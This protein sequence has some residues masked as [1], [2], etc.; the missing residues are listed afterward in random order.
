MLLSARIA[1][2]NGFD[3]IIVVNLTTLSETTNNNSTIPNANNDNSTVH[4]LNRR[5][6]TV[7]LPATAYGRLDTSPAP[8]TVAGIIL[9]TVAGFL[10]LLYLLYAT[11]IPKKPIDDAA[12]VEVEEVRRPRPRPRRGWNGWGRGGRS[13]G[14]S[15]YGGSEEGGGD[16][17][18]VFEEESVES[19]RREPVRDT[20][21]ERDRGAGRSWWGWGRGRQ[22]D[23]RSTDDG[24]TVEVMEEGDG[25]YAPPPPPM[26]PPAPMQRERR[27]KRKSRRARRTDD[28]Y[29]RG[30]EDWGFYA[31]GLFAGLL[32]MIA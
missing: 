28:P 11:F 6:Q 29:E 22:A 20:G 10:L 31:V 3:I 30:S 5:Y 14:G 15:R 13:G 32:V 16:F 21:R 7:S 19:P 4:A 25:Y 26:P 17:V 9:G 2:K 23:D 27:K 12:T 8:G 1:V 18:D 24:G